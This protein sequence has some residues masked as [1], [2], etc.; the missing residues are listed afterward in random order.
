MNILLNTSQIQT[1][2]SIQTDLAQ[3]SYSHVTADEL[4][5]SAEVQAAWQQLQAAYA[6]LPADNFLPGGAAYRFR[7]YDSFQFHPTTGE[8]ALLPHRAY[9]QNTDINAVTG[10]IARDFAP[11]TSEIAANPF[12]HELIRFDFAQFP[13]DEALRQA[14]WKVDVHLVRVVARA[15][16]SAH[17]TPEGVH[18]DGA[19][20]VTVHLAELENA[21][22]GEASIY[23]DRKRHLASF[24]LQNV[25]DSYLFHD[26]ILWHGAKPIQPKNGGQ[27]I[28]SILTF[29][30]HPQR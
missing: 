28:R 15:G 16:E 3:Q 27:G 20:Y 4:Q 29:D 7:R 12:L 18:R 10:G 21:V 26:A 6:E 5:L 24:T 25:L 17:P 11:L 1:T 23:D 9:F 13:I 22:G 2:H 14:N 8:L 30:Y 19:E